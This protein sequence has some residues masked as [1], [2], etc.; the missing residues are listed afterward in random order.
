MAKLRKSVDK[1]PKRNKAKAKP[2]AIPREWE[3]IF[4]AIGQPSFILKPNFRI[5]ACNKTIANLT[6]EPMENLIGKRCC[7]VLHG[8]K[9]P[10]DDCPMEKLLKSF[11]FET[12]EME[13]EALGRVFFVS[14]TPI[15]DRTGKLD[16][17]I[18]IA[19]DVTDRKRAQE[20]LRDN[21][22]KLK[23]LAAE[24]SYAEEHERRRI[25][26]GIHDNIGQ[27]LAMAKLKLQFIKDSIPEPIAQSAID[28]ACDI[29]NEIIDDTRSLVF[30]L[31]NP[32][33][34]E[35]GLEE[36]VVTFLKNEI[37]DKGGPKCKYMPAGNKIELDEDAKVVLF[38]AIRELLINILKHAVA[39]NIKVGI[40]KQDNEV[41]VIVEDDGTGFDVSRLGL[42][43]GTKGGFGLF[44][45]RERLEYMGGRLEIE[46]RPG[47][48]TRIVMTAPITKPE[49]GQEKRNLYE[50]AHSR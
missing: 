37:K 39:R 15:F 22:K 28:S 1:R 8:K 24:L 3:G 38:K 29:M 43:S 30:E 49:Q 5:I 26:I 47:K 7:E 35:I 4:H 34:Y 48:G 17:I 13:V 23:A 19:N 50:S 31:S 44:N 36:A 14:C 11:S 2:Q 9:R 40:S 20:K 45:I 33:L 16:R 6:D 10:P 21:Q 18:H 25:A 27:K 32:I 46:S 12:A 42:P 41:K